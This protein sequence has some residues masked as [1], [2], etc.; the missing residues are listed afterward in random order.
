MMTAVLLVGVV[1]ASLFWTV[2][3]PH[4]AEPEA[5]VYLRSTDEV[6]VSTLGEWLTFQPAEGSPTVGF[7]F[8]PGGNV[9]YQAYAPALFEI[10]AQGFLVVDVPMPLDLA[11]LG[12]G[13]AA[14]VIAAHPEIGHWAIGG[15]SLGGAMAS[16]FAYENPAAVEGVVLWAAYPA[17]SNDLSGTG[18]QVI[19]V[20]DTLDGVATP[21]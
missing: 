15:H 9:D 21:E 10:A 16:R 19:S 3:S 20:Y 1:I 11:I 14:D 2:G 4:T 18:L 8:Y 12:Y 17:G 7:I 13:Q 6:R 5:E